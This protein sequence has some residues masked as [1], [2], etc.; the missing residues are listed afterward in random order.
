MFK[1]DEKQPVVLIAED[2]DGHSLQLRR[3][4]SNLGKK[5][6]Y[7]TCETAKRLPPI[8]PARA[9]FIDAVDWIRAQPGFATPHRGPYNQ[10]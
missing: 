2:D 10:R 7:S 4:L 6:Q 9:S 8:S 1:G 5:G 3:A